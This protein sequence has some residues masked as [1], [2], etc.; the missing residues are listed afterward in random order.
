MLPILTSLFTLFD[1]CKY[2]LE[3]NNLVAAITAGSGTGFTLWG[4]TLQ[5]VSLFWGTMVSFLGTLTVIMVFFLTLRKTVRT[6]KEDWQ[7]H[8]NNKQ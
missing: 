4:F 3:N 8:K 7:E 6:I 5:D 1:Q 2:Q